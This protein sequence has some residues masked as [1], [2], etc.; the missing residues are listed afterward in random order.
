MRAHILITC[1]VAAAAPNQSS[2]HHYRDLWCFDIPT[3]SWERFDTKT[4]P[5]ARSG[6]R[7]AMWKHYVFLFGGFQDV[8]KLAIGLV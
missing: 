1:F 6:H 5:S 4:R 2:F 7:M 3:H 8:G